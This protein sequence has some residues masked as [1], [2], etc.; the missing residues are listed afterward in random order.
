MMF[1]CIITQTMQ[2][3]EVQRIKL[4]GH[5]AYLPDFSPCDFCL[6]PKIKEQLHGKYFQDINELHATVHEQ[7]E[8]LQKED[9]YQCYEQWFERM[10]KCISAQGYYFEQ[11]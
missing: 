9:F 4:M 8:D 6:F 7:M 5:P 2:Y 11:I 3:L 10:N 1:S